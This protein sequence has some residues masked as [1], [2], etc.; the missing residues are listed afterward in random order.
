MVTKFVE[1]DR[2]SIVVGF[3][4]A[5]CVY[6]C[7]VGVCLGVCRVLFMFGVNRVGFVSGDSGL[8]VSSKVY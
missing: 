4:D 5:V 3:G 2:S 8:H 6:G 1:S 7:G